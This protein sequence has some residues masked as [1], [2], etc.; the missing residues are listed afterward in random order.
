MNNKNKMSWYI[1]IAIIISIFVGHVGVTLYTDYENNKLIEENNKKV[2]EY[3]E[4]LE[5]EI[6]NTRNYL[7]NNQT[8]SKINKIQVELKQL[9]KDATAQ[10]FNNLREI[11]YGA[12]FS[13]CTILPLYI[14]K[15]IVKNTQMDICFSEY[16]DKILLTSGVISAIMFGYDIY[17]RVSD[18]NKI[19][20]VTNSVSKLF[21]IIN[22]WDNYI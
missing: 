6:K 16:T 7:K 19:V 5:L 18:I 1:M 14:Y 4:Q 21:N 17:T 9:E 2:E 8:S 10:I 15:I 12:L 13:V 11:L 20:D 22:E 3:R